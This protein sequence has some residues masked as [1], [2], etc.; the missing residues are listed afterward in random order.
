[1]LKRFFAW[2]GRLMRRRHVAAA[3][4]AVPPA[5]IPGTAGKLDFSQPANSGLLLL[6][7]DS[8]L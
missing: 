3:I 4:T 8:L 5:P 7:E 2:I 6:L 1:M